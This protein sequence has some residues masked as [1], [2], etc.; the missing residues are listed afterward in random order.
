M[1]AAFDHFGDATNFNDAFLKSGVFPFLRPIVS[2]SATASLTALAS[3]ALA[4][5]I[6]ACARAAAIPSAS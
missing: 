2:L 4:T 6:A 5:A 3:C 1:A